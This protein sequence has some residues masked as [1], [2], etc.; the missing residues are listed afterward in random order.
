MSSTG[1]TYGST[2]A[3]SSC[4][5]KRRKESQRHSELSFRLC[6]LFRQHRNLTQEIVLVFVLFLFRFSSSNKKHGTMMVLMSRRR[7]PQQS[8]RV[9]GGVAALAA[10]ATPAKREIAPMNTNAKMDTSRNGGGYRE[11]SRL[12]AQGT[13][14]ANPYNPLPP[15]DWTLEEK[16]RA[17]A[18]LPD[19]ET[20]MGDDDRENGRRLRVNP[21]HSLPPLPTCA[22][23]S[24][25][26]GGGS[27]NGGGGAKTRGAVAGQKAP[28]SWRQRTCAKSRAVV[29]DLRCRRRK[30]SH[31]KG[32]AAE[33]VVPER[34]G[35]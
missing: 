9:C 1:A 31:G 11:A 26:G 34:S 20:M 10:P 8:Q 12:H 4:S 29:Q 35:V 27:R 30:A 3:Q 24:S 28:P 21:A 7:M 17:A 15:N 13:A 32:A 5:L 22:G 16:G 33:Q 25:V 18:A 14:S 2:V 19:R 23:G 6:F